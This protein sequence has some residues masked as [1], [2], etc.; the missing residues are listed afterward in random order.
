VEDL[1]LRGLSYFTWC[2]YL[3]YPG[4]F[5][6]ECDYLLYCYNINEWMVGVRYYAIESL[7]VHYLLCTFNLTLQ[8]CL[9]DL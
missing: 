9:V 4:I 1:V 7:L 6:S 3:I 8:F 2:R 5:I